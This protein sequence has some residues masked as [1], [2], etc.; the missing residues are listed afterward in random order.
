M[1]LSERERERE[2]ER[3]GLLRDLFQVFE[4]F[5]IFVNV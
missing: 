3:G 1:V 4:Q 5:V 2:R